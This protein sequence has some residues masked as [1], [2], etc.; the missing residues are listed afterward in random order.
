[1]RDGKRGTRAKD[2][3]EIAAVRSRALQGAR[4]TEQQ[5]RRKEGDQNRSALRGRESKGEKTLL[6]QG[7]RSQWSDTLSLS[8]SVCLLLLAFFLCLVCPS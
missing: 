7:S 6:G 5:K 3:R 1:M 8:L 4:D 2:A